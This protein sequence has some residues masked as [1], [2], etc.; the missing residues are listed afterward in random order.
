M[1]ECLYCDGPIPV[2]RHKN[3]MTCSK[4]HAKLL[5]KEREAKN[6]TIVRATADPIIKLRE[7]FYA[8]A[9]EFGFG[10]PIDLDY[11]SPFKI[12]WSLKTGTF[13]RDGN[14]G[15]ALGDIGYILFKPQSIK[16]YKL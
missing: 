2:E 11:I 16:I 6:Y 15:V 4:E 8:V 13:I 7:N 1:S 3:A 10:V 9:Y 12:D 5:K 14:I